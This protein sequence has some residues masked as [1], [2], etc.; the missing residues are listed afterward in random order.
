MSSSLKIRNPADFDYWPQ[1][2]NDTG[3]AVRVVSRK[4]FGLLLRQH[5]QSEVVVSV[6]SKRKLVF[7][8]GL[9]PDAENKELWFITGPGFKSNKLAALKVWRHLRE[10][11]FTGSKPVIACVRKETDKPGRIARLAG[12][13]PTGR[14][15]QIGPIEY[16]VYQ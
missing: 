6:W 3:S 10:D 14:V 15:N 8:V 4:L 2:H 9:W 5:V 1:V 16:E 12:L 11:F 7:V 13:A